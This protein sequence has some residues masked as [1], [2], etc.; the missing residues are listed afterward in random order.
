VTQKADH[1][2]FSIRN[3]PWYVWTLRLAWILWLLLW[4]EFAIGSRQE[5]EPHAF[6]IAVKVLIVS[7]L[8]GLGLYF[9][10]LRDP[11]KGPGPEAEEAEAT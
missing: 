4:L 9:W 1:S 11:G 10:K 2:I 6:S 7:V 8:L 5:M 3:R